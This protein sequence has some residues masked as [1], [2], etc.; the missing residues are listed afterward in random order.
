MFSKFLYKFKSFFSLINQKR[1]NFQK[2]SSFESPNG[3]MTQGISKGT[4]SIKIIKND[5]KSDD[6]FSI[7]VYTQGNTVNLVTICI[8]NYSK[9]ETNQKA[10]EFD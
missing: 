7:L 1:N 6:Q 10:S 8:K 4:I 3:F 2:I 9:I 5:R